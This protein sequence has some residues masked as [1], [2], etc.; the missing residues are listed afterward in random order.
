MSS[1][2]VYVAP[3]KPAVIV[4]GG[5]TLTYGELEAE[6]NAWPPVSGG[7]GCGRGDT[8]RSWLE[9]RRAEA[10]VIAW[11]AQRSGLYYTAASTR[12]GVDELVTTSSPTARPGCSSPRRRHADGG[13]A[14]GGADGRAAADPV[15]GAAEGW[16]PLEAAVAACLLDTPID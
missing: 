8:S 7:G 4:D 10:F 2:I 1:Q 3:D 11:A 13:V 16:E 14:G 6:S 12:L 9:N 5:R 15:T